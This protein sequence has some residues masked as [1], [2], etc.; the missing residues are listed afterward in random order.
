[1]GGWSQFTQGVV[2]GVAVFLVAASTIADSQVAPSTQIVV[3]TSQDVGPY[4]EVLQGFRQALS[5]Q[6]LQTSII[7]LSAAG[8]AAKALSFIHD[9]E[10]LDVHLLVTL[11]SIATRAAI[12]ENVS[13]PLLAS[14]VMNTNDLRK[15][16]N[17]T[18]VVL[19]FPVDMQLQWLRRFLPEQTTVGVLFNPKENHDMITA[20]TL[21]ASQLGLQLAAQEVH[22][23]QDLP[24][25]LEHMA[26]KAEVLW[27]VTDP[28][29]LSS[30]T[31]EPILLFSFRNRI[32]FTGLSS[33][34]VKAGALYALDRDYADLGVQCGEI[35]L[36]ILNGA[37]ANTFPPVSPR[38]VTYSINLKTAEHMKIEIPQSL[39]D[40][41]QQVFR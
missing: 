39:I 14:L 31:A 27:G 32:P 29:V 19:E 21:A 13:F 12:Q 35:A 10:K 25:A 41:A 22:T 28:T 37:Q 1:M 33:S 4:Q 26:E 24:A 5:H 7:V 3:L 20:A 34:W 30:Q 40:G 15:L 6:S 16:T 38:K 2:V 23:P 8:D 17:A 36:Q 11:G 9:L 18:A